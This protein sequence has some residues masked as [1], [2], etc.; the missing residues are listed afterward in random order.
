M[1]VLLVEDE[2]MISMLL[3]DMVELAG[4]AVAGEAGSVDRALEMIEEFAPDAAI[5]DLRLHNRDSY[6]VMDRLRE[7]GIPFAVASGFGSDID[8]ER[9][10]EAVPIV[11][12]PYSSG[13]VANV[14]SQLGG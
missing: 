9:A 1:N 8:R 14:L 7:R 11:S 4:H 12:K 2:P 3:C 10:G 5:V 6:P 13:E